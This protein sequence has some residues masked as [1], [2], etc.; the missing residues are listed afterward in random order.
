MNSSSETGMQSI[1]RA[2][3]YQDGEKAVIYILA[4]QDTQDE[5]WV[6]KA[7]SMF[8]KSKI[9]YIHYKNI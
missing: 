9:N 4:Y 6:D 3:N 2:C 5:K 7:I 1:M 8:P